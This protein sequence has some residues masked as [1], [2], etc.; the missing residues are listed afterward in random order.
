MRFLTRSL[1]ALF[2]A[3][4]SLGFL[5][6]AGHVLRDALQ[7]RAEAGD[8]PRMARER[9]FTVQ[10][11]PFQPDA[12]TPE[13]SAFGEVRTRRALE[14]RVPVGGRVLELAPGFEDGAG[15]VEGQL[16]LRIDPAD[17]QAARD[18]AQTDMLR[19]DAEL[20]DASRA[21]VLAREDVAAAEEQLALRQR[22]LERRQ[23][24]AERGVATEA[25]LEDAELALS[26]ARQALVSRR[27]A[28]AQ[29][30]AR[31]DQA[32]TA[33]DRQ[34]ITLTEAERRLADTE[35]RATFSGVLS[36]V[37]VV[38]GGIVG[39]NERLAR[40]IDPES[41]EVAFRVSTAQYLRLLDD[42]GDLIEAPVDVTLE[43]SGMDISTPA[44]L[45][46]VGASVAEGQSG[47][48]LYAALD[49][50][51]GFRPG[52]FVTVRVREP[53]LDQV[54]LLPAAAV[55]SAGNVLVVDADS[56]L[57]AH[58]VEILRRQGDHV[59]VRAGPAL[60]GRDVV[61][62]IGPMLG[63]GILVSPNRA[64]GADADTPAGP[65]MV[66][67]DPE[68]RAELI[69]RIE[70]N[71]AMPEP[72]RARLIAQLEQDE[73]PAQTLERLESGHRGG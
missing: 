45:T 67:L 34:R 19:A 61:R 31:R 44:R 64:D 38:E 27:Q 49:A 72:V 36:D 13:L 42:H 12:L 33:R 40:V 52:D 68:R 32:E 9:A 29:A 65:Q 51:R 73:V 8:R 48:L 30:E 63:T 3:A 55:D 41:L 5:G 16:L 20:R 21:V 47:R 56:R 43:I 53:A 23:S 70:G 37:A 57:E 50:A 59:I 6:Y 62:E 60:A 35:L 24:L 1:L 2:L 25:A 66:R 10:V 71:T 58:P 46:R 22:A 17:A 7:E 18:L 11:I 4:L 69:A 54:A 28:Q 39:A 26:S 15:V 14:L